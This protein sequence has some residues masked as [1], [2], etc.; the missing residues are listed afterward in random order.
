MRQASVMK[1]GMCAYCGAENVELTI[2]HVF[3]ESWYPDDTARSAMLTVPA[4]S[5]CNARFDKIE[6]PMFLPLALTLPSDPRFDLIV[7]RAIRSAD[8]NVAKSIRDASHRKK[9][10]DSIMGRS[11]I[12]APEVPIPNAMWNPHGRRLAEF[13]TESGESILG[14]A[15]IHVPWANT[16]QLAFKLLRGCYFKTYGRVLGDAHPLWARAFHDDPRDYAMAW[17]R[18][19][20]AVTAGNFPFKYTI[21][22]DESHRAGAFFIL[23]DFVYLFAANINEPAAASASGMPRA[24]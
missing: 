6:K 12:V 16:E 3:P 13:T 21:A 15:T 14:S 1:R 17:Q 7:E 5:A 8:P 24:L 9:R 11:R 18:A 20:G 23:W 22:E 10:G 19:P 4:C 2:E